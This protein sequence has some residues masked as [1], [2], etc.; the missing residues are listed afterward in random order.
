MS[1]AVGCDDLL[2]PKFCK[3]VQQPGQTLLDEQRLLQL[4]MH[5]LKNHGSVVQRVLV[6][7]ETSKASVL[8]LCRCTMQ[9]HTRSQVTAGR[10]IL[11]ALPAL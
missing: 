6:A 7:A 5:S 11:L 10:L 9:L 3:P 8:T 2:A 1:I 4:Y